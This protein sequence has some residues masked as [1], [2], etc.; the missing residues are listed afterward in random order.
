M[1][2]VRKTNQAQRETSVEALMQAALRLFVDNGF[3]QTS[4]DR[5][6]EAAGLSKG[7]VYF[8]FDSK[9][10]LLHGLLDQG[11]NVIVDRMVKTIAGAGPKASDKI[12]LFVNT[13]AEL[14]VTDPDRVLLLILSSLE[15]HNKDGAINQRLRAIYARMYAILED[16]IEL[17]KTQGVFRGDLPTPVQAAIVMAGHDG[18]FLEWYRRK[19]SLDGP[20]LVRALRAATLAG[21]ATDKSEKSNKRRAK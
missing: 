8:Y 14:G 20:E 5:I 12:A 4:V 6:A 9:E 3:D 11:E 16:V 17:G 10:A 1:A 13:Q 7:A 21:L 18:T 15:F 2:A 19:D